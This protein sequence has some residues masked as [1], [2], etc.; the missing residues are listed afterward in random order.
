MIER[1]NS[2][3]AIHYG[4]PLTEEWELIEVFEVVPS[5]TPDVTTLTIEEIWKWHRGEWREIHLPN[6]ERIEVQVVR[7]TE[8]N[9]FILNVR[10][11]SES[12]LQIICDILTSVIFRTLKLAIVQI[13]YGASERVES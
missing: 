4:N 13:G 12:L 10:Q 11:G 9:T 7:H 6:G 2:Q 1:R 3:A 8:N 5:I